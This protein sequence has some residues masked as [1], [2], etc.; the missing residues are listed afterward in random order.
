MRCEVGRNAALRSLDYL[1]VTPPFRT[2]S[3]DPLQNRVPLL[4]PPRKHAHQFISTHPLA[5][6][7]LARLQLRTHPLP[8][9]RQ[10]PLRLRRA[11]KAV[12]EVRRCAI[13]KRVLQPLRVPV[14]RVLHQPHVHLAQLL[15]HRRVRVYA[16]PPPTAPTF[17]NHGLLVERFETLS[18]GRQEVAREGLQHAVQ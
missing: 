13:A 7:L 5:P 6:R 15:R 12:D 8:Q 16:S 10:Q 1:L 4:L 2:H 18:E 14:H 11:R 17:R 3:M 9:L